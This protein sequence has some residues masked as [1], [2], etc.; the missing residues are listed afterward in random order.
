MTSPRSTAVIEA[1]RSGQYSFRSKMIGP[2][3]RDGDTDLGAP[4]ALPDRGRGGRGR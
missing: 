1:A 2:K 3:G 4:G